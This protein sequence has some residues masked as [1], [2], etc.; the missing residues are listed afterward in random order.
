M[1]LGRP[2]VTI[3]EADPAG[4]EA[5]ACL[6]SYYAEL[7]RR[8][9]GG[10]DVTLSRDP[11]AAAMRRPRGVF[12]LAAGTSGPVGC[13]GLRG[14]GEWA[15]V[16]RLWISADARGAGVASRLMARI[17]TVARDLGMVL[18]RLDTNAALTEAAALYR[19]TGWTEI[20]RFNDDPYA[21]IFFE[22]R[23]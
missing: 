6:S 15:E 3:L 16:K 21:Q 1:T 19:K 4:T 11:E 12:L 5:R 10:F 8:L 7:A 17:E 9:P 2:R 18:L 13:V 23:L 14:H 22:K 20:P